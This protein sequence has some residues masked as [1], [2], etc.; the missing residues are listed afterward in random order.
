MVN[1]LPRAKAS[2]VGTER[3]PLSQDHSLDMSLRIGLLAVDC[4]SGRL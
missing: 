2:F 3:Q 1:H 4:V